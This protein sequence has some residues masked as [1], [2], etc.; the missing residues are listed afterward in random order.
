NVD[1][2]NQRNKILIIAGD[3]NAAAASWG[4]F[5]PNE[6]GSE[7][8]EW[9]AREGLEVVNVGKVATFNRRDQEAH[10]D[11]TIADEKALRHICKWRVQ[12][13]H[14]SLSDH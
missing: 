10:I 9:M 2:R 8:E 7:L 1:A 3:L 12:T 14:E 6:R 4:S 13:E 11:V 5:R